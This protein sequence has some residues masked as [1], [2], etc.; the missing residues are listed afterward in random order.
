[1]RVLDQPASEI[2]G[3]GKRP[4]YTN[5]RNCTGLKTGRYKR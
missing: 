4:R 2:A 3:L 1:M 5:W